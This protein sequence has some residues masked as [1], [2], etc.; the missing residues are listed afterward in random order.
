MAGSGGRLASKTGGIGGRWSVK[1]YTVGGWP[2][3][4]VGLVGGGL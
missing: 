1:W 3:K 2:P 4:Q